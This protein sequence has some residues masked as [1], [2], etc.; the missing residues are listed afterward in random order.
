MVILSRGPWY[1]ASSDPDHF[2]D[3]SDTSS[4]HGVTGLTKSLA[5]DGRKYNIS[6][7]QIDIGNASSDMTQKDDDWQRCNA[8]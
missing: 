4:K 6:L 8:S 5:L 3:F 7:S 2:F 1:T